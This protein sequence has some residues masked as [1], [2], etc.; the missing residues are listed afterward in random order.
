[1]GDCYSSKNGVSCQGEESKPLLP[2]SSNSLYK[3]NGPESH[4]YSLP[5]A[6]A[7][8]QA[9]LSCI[10]PRQLLTSLMF[11]LQISKAWS[12]LNHGHS[13]AVQHLV[14]HTE[15]Q[16]DALEEAPT[17]YV[18]PVTPCPLQICNRSPS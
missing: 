8:E 16:L 5:S 4:H 7:G 9:L 17:T 18:L 3:S 2:P 6:R 1:M 13:Q 15:Q 10:L 12:N 14:G 11:R